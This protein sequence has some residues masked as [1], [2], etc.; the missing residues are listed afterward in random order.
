MESASG[1][2]LGS[3][4][5]AR[6]ASSSVAAPSPQETARTSPHKAI[7]D[8]DLKFIKLRIRKDIKKRY[9]ILYIIFLCTELKK[10]YCII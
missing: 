8:H 1:N 5:A 4:R 3:W 10:I 6:T 2:S 7:N 9:L